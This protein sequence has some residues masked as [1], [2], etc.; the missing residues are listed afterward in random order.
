M[1]LL[2]RRNVGVVDEAEAAV[3]GLT[4]L[5]AVKDVV[6]LLTRGVHPEVEFKSVEEAQEEESDHIPG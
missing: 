6:V 1:I 2:K 3:E 4:E 5:V